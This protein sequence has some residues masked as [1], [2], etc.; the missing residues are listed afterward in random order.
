MITDE[1]CTSPKPHGG[2]QGPHH[3]LMMWLVSSRLDTHSGDVA[4]VGHSDIAISAVPSLITSLLPHWFSPP[5][6]PDHRIPRQHAHDGHQ[7]YSQS[8]FNHLPAPS[9]SLSSTVL[10]HISD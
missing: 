6:I 1:V 10:S 2:R 3:G 4:L 9:T 7:I 8:T 5:S